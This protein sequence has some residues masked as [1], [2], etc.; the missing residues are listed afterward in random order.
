VRLSR[1]ADDGDIEILEIAQKKK[2]GL[3]SSDRTVYEVGKDCGI[4]MFIFSNL[5]DTAYTLGLINSSEIKNAV[6]FI[7]DVVKDGF[8]KEDKAIIDRIIDEING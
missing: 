8:L 5:V 6:Y 7:E 2:Y 4:E 3:I 1:Q